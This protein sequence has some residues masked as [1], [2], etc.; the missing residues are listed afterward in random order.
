MDVGGKPGENGRQ[1]KECQEEGE[2]KKKMSK[3]K[4]K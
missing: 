4:E 2:G 3:A 1:W